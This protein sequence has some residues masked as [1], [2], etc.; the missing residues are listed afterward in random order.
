VGGVAQLGRD[1]LLE[2]L[3]EHVL[4]HLGFLMDAIPRHPE[5]LDQVQL[6]QSV[7][8]Y[9][10]ERN[11]P[12]VLGQR[13]AA[14]R[15]VLDQAQFVQA[16]DHARCRCRGHAESVGQRVRAD[17]L[18]GAPLERVDR[19]G[20]V[21]NRRRTERGGVLAGHDANYGTPKFEFC[22]RHVRQVQPIWPV[23]RVAY[24]VFR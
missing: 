15:L 14:I 4:E 8:A 9:D 13:Y 11:P 10:L 18:A 12:A 20:V 3:G 7:M 6:E 5:R 1:Q 16:L 22:K 2:L 21:L 17:R 19:L 24:A 23:P